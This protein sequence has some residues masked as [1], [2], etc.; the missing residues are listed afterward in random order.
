MKRRKSKRFLVGLAL[1]AL[2]VGLGGGQ[3]AWAESNLAVGGSATAH[4]DFQINI[5]TILYL[6][7]GNAGA[8]VD[9]VS[10]TLS[11]IPGTGAVAMHSNGPDPV[12]VTMSGFVTA[13]Q[14]MTLLADS[15]NDLSAGG[16]SK[17]PFD[18]ISWTGGGSIGG[19]TFNKAT[20]QQIAQRTGSG[21]LTGTMAFSYANANYYDAGTYNGQV[22]YTLSSP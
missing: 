19:N 12:P 21:T 16:S 22:T 20:N 4:L 6:Q 9:R 17:I 5:P 14:T 1:L 3:A 15:S 8:T 7:V 13:G 11:D 2:A 10:C 18:Q